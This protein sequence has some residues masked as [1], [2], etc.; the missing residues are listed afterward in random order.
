MEPLTTGK[1]DVNPFHI[2]FLFDPIKEAYS[3]FSGLLH[4]RS[5]ERRDVDVEHNQM[6]DQDRMR[7]C[8]VLN[9]W[10]LH[11][12]EPRTCRDIHVLRCALARAFGQH[13]AAANLAL[14]GMPPVVCASPSKLVTRGLCEPTQIKMWCLL[15]VLLQNFGIEGPHFGHGFCSMMQVIGFIASQ[16]S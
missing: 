7:Y 9:P 14:S 5:T 2:T 16:Q 8:C 11:W 4:V 1:N 13:F 3:R 6:V 15:M 12:I 10:K